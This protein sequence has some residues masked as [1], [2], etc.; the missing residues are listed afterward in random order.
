[1]TE[2]EGLAIKK[3]SNFHEKEVSQSQ[4]SLTAPTASFPV[5]LQKCCPLLGP[6]SSCTLKAEHPDAEDIALMAQMPLML[7]GSTSLSHTGRNTLACDPG[8]ER[9]KFQVGRAG[10]KGRGGSL[11]TASC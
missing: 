8:G 9:F 7:C 3:T 1:M 11:L 5:P 2:P 6:L 4:V 10:A